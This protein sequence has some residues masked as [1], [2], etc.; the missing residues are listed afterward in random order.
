MTEE[1]AHVKERHWRPLVH[2]PMGGLGRL[3]NSEA[4]TIL[5]TNES[6]YITGTD[7]LVDA[8]LSSAAEGELVLSPP[9]NPF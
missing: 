7:F 5:A 6:G 1:T 8:R 2:F 3:F 4:G 9:A